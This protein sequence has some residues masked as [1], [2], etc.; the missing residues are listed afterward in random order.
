MNDMDDQKVMALAKEKIGIKNTARDTYLTAIS[1]GVINELEEENGLTLD[2]TNYRHLL[3]VAD[4]VEFRFNNPNADM[5]R[6]LKYRLHNLLI[7][8]GSQV[9]T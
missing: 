9:A 5:P 3:F 1:K 7:H 6:H 8:D 2:D 4:Y